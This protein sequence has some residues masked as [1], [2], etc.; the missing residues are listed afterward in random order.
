MTTSEETGTPAMTVGS[1]PG[2]LPLLGHLLP[3]AR[4]PLAF[5]RS[6]PGH[7]DLVSIGFGPRTAY[8]VCHPALADTVLRNARVFDK[9]GPFWEQARLAAGDGVGTCTHAPHR[10]QRR[11]VQPAFHPHKMPDYAAVMAEE[12]AAAIRPWRDGQMLDVL[13]VLDAVTARVTARCLFAADL[14]P[15]ETAATGRSLAAVLE[16]MFWGMLTPSGLKWVPTPSSRRFRH[17]VQQLDQLVYRLIATQRRGE[18]DRGGMLAALIASRDENGDTLD[19]REIRDQLLNF[20]IAGTET[21][22]AL[23]AWTLYL[24]TGHPHAQQRLHTEVD[25]VLAGRTAAHDD[26]PHLPYTYQVLTETLR[27]FPP[28]WMVTRTVTE[29]TQLAGHPLPA[30][31]TLLYS[32][33]LIHH[34]ADLYCDPE[35]FDPDRWEPE[36]ATTLPRGAFTPFGAGARKCMGDTFGMQEATLTLATITACWK[37]DLPPANTTRP[38]ARATLRPHPLHMRLH[39]RHPANEGTP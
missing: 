37:L 32:P 11:L 34:R 19:D 2:R 28:A 14:G 12:T 25:T 5:L 15:E 3:L 31:T 1:A 26:L 9:G 20:I 8:V 33:Y 38:Q 35:R 7:G 21:S 6:L 29:D 22:A 36:Q 24:L 4:R 16:G 10:R 30:G 23:V 18:A 17:A 39:Q 13:A 27:L